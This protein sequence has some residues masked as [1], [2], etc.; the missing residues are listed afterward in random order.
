VLL[1]AVVET[2]PPEV[3]SELAAVVSELADVAVVLLVDVEPEQA[4]SPRENASTSASSTIAGTTPL[5]TKR[6]IFLLSSRFSAHA[7]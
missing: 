1:P 2:V 6:L 5:L 4:M 7:P 3:V